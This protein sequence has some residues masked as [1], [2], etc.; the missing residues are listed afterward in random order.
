MFRLAAIAE[1]TP[2]YATTLLTRVRTVMIT[3]E[4][5]RAAGVML[6]ATVM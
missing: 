4:R 6:A 3:A 2:A 1:R 5:I